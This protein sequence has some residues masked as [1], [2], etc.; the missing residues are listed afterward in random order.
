MQA[1]HDL[2]NMNGLSAV[3]DKYDLLFYGGNM[4]Q[5]M[6]QALIDMDEYFATRDSYQRISNLVY[7]ISISPEFS[8]QQ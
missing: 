6:R 1:D 8:L 4:S 2:I 5:E 7:L 3:L